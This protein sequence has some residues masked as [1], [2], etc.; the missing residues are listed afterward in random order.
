MGKNQSCSEYA[1][2]HRTAYSRTNLPVPT[3]SGSRIFPL[4]CGQSVQRFD[5]QGALRLYTELTAVTRSLQYN[6]KVKIEDRITFKEPKTRKGKRLIALTPSNAIVLREHY[7]KENAQRLALG[8]PGLNNNDLVFSHYDGSPF[9]PNTITHAWIKITRRCG[10][11]GIRLHDA[12]HTHA[13]LL[14]K[15]GVHPKVVQ[16]R[17]GH[18]SIQVTLD[19]YS[20]V[21]PGLQQAAAEKFDSIALPNK[22]ASIKIN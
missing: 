14:L 9:L 2:L 17:P 8:Y 7:E 16:E 11:D 5:W 15:Q 18:G 6:S 4:A 22:E 10:L 3:S 1:E 13:S 12:R 19:T 21:A 20:H